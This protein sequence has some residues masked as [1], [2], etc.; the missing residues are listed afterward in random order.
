MVTTDQDTPTV[1]LAVEPH[2]VAAGPSG[3]L[4]IVLAL[5]VGVV[6]GALIALLLPR[7][8][9]PRRSLRPSADPLDA[10]DTPTVDEESAPG[11]ER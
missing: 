8:D 11:P 5:A 9:G 4:R 1:E 10:P 2:D 3:W 7:D 6:A